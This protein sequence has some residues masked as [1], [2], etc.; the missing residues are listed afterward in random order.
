MNN[1]KDE[2]TL[3]DLKSDISETI[4]I[5]EQIQSEI[6]KTIDISNR[7]NKLLKDDSKKSKTIILKNIKIK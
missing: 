7:I 1:I 5:I 2:Y 6:S 3:N 4:S